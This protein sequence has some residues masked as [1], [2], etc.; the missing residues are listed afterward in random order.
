MRV[1]VYEF[2]TGGGWFGRA[3]DVPPESLAC[4]GRAMLAALAADFVAAGCEVDVLN[5]SRQPHFDLPG[6]T[7][8]AIRSSRDERRALLELSAA[9][10]WTVL[11]APEFD[12]E[13]LT[14]AR[15][16]E[17]GGG[18]LLGPS[19]QVVA[20]ASDKQATVECLAR[21]G[22]SVPRGLALAAGESLPVDFGYPAVLKPRDGCG[23]LDIRSVAT[24]DDEPPAFAARLESFCPG[25]AASVACLCEPESIVPLA[26]C[27]Q[28]LDDDFAYLGG[29]LP[30]A[31]A[32]AGRAQRLA[33]RAVRAL[34]RPFGYLGVDLVLGDDP[35]GSGDVVVEINPR[36]TTSYVGLR[37]LSRV[38]LADAMVR[39]AGGQ[40][41]ELCWNSGEV[42]FTSAGLVA[43]N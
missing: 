3:D 42:R 2:V 28:L 18:R 16:V 4:E 5:D 14:R 41:V 43:S 40:H 10:D 23:S 21:H 8:H 38:N 39:I 20:L 25:L 26:P 31:P 24:P 9:A 15:L 22:V 12:G 32:L 7:I 27:R 35:A 33:H 17:K 29:S 37:A 30:L 34:P 6:A 1:L 36:L 11:I 19:S 13:L